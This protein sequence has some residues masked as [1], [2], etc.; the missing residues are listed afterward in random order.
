[1][2]DSHQDESWMRYA[3]DLA[4]RCPPSDSAFNVGA[5]VV[6]NNTIVAQGYSR[7]F[8]PLDHAEEVAL[9]QWR[10][11]EGDPV[12]LSEASIYSTLEPCGYRAS[13]PTPCAR[14]IID[15]GL[16]RVVYAQDEPD[17][18]VSAPSGAD[19]LRRARINI[20]YLAKLADAAWELNGHLMLVC[21]ICH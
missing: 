18:F 20:I 9:R 2:G 14:H 15:S 3:I 13:R 21:R 6:A 10:E 5:V 1:M 4:K 19:Q 12:D 16:R 8:G 7:Q 11:T 17:T